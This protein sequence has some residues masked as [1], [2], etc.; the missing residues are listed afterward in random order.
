M[1]SLKPDKFSKKGPF[2]L[3]SYQ[4]EYQ[5]LLKENF[6]KDS[7]IYIEDLKILNSL[8]V[9]SSNFLATINGEKVIIKILDDLSKD[10]F[11]KKFAFYEFLSEKKVH[12]PKLS[13]MYQDK[14]IRNFTFKK[15]ILFLEYIKGRYFNGSYEDLKK[16]SLSLENL[17]KNLMD[18]KNDLVSELKIYPENADYIC[19][20]FF[21]LFEKKSFEF[22]KRINTLITKNKEH[23][24]KS[25]KI[26][27]LDLKRVKKEK[28]EIFHI[29]L[30]PH[31]IL[32]QKDKAFIIDIDS[33]MLSR[34]HIGMGFTFFKLIRQT[35]TKKRYP[36]ILKIKSINFL[37]TAF[38]SSN[39]SEFLRE[40]ILGARIEIMRRIL[41]IFEENIQTGKS[42]WND[43][44]E[45]QIQSL[46]DLEIFERIFA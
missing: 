27:I 20:N 42:S 6:F 11:K 26:N 35:M 19:E 22:N 5:K 2:W 28:K 29:D 44:L 31:N 17:N 32:I 3:D 15:N 41:Y 39:D 8:Q 43:V 1:T 9:N 24:F 33:I 23:V 34:W 37:K 38:G 30:H 7:G 13:K 21:H 25:N 18:I 4:D 36:K 46:N 16:T 45:I 10:E 14:E 12:T 40:L